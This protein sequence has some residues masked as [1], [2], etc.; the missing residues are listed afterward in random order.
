MNVKVKEVDKI[1]IEVP[2]E[3]NESDAMEEKNTEKE[4][5]RKGPFSPICLD[6]SALSYLET[7]PDKTFL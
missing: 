1:V 5:Q 6:W 2:E 7:A 3:G 4:K